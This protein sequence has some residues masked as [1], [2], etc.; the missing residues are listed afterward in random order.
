MVFIQVD[1]IRMPRSS[2]QL[3]DKELNQEV[4]KH[5]CYYVPNKMAP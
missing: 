1:L 4:A 3:Q 2:M 5:F